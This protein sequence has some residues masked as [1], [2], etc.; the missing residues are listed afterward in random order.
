[1]NKIDGFCPETLSS[2]GMVLNTVDFLHFHKM[3]SIWREGMQ[4]DASLEDSLPNDL[5]G[6]TWFPT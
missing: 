3:E 6:Q 2:V 4:M 1:M 5:I